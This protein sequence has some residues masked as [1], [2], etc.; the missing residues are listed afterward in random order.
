[1]YVYDQLQVDKP[2]HI[3]NGGGGGLGWSGGGTIGVKLATDCF[4]GDG[5]GA[6]ADQI[7]QDGMLQELDGTG[8]P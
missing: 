7:T 1:M 4:L 3:V 6:S 2:G 5:Q 8:A